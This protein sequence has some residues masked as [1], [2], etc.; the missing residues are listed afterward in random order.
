M[1]E[2]EAAGPQV[3]LEIGP[4]RAGEDVGREALVVHADHAGHGREVEQH[5]AVAGHAGAAH[6]AAAA[7]GGDGHT[8]LV[9]H[10]EHGG[11][12]AVVDRPAHHRRQRAHLPGQRPVHRQRPPV[13]ARL[14]PGRRVGGRGRAGDGQRLQHRRIE[15]RRLREARTHLRGRSDELDGRGG[16]GHSGPEGRVQRLIGGVTPGRS[17]V[18]DGTAVGSGLP[19]HVLVAPAELGGEQTGHPRRR[20]RS[21]GAVEQAGPR[22]AGW[23]GSRLQAHDG[24]HAGQRYTGH[25]V[26]PSVRQHLGRHGEYRLGSGLQVT[27]AWYVVTETDSAL[28]EGSYVKGTVLLILR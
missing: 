6:A 7:G 28:R 11:D 16:C 9:A 21:G 20:L 3:G 18:L 22:A 5:A 2:G 15:G 27:A 4:E 26:H 25:H 8:V 17:L 13:P 24:M 23:Y 12:L 10:A 1:P 14:G 19:L